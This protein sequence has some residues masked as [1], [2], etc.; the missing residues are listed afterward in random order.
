MNT[1]RQKYV[2]FRVSDSE[3]EQL[4][5]RIKNSGLNKQQFFIREVLGKSLPNEKLFQ[6]LL[7]EIKKQGVNLNQI[8]RAC[9]RGYAEAEQ[10]RIREA[11]NLNNQ[12]WKAVMLLLNTE[13]KGVDLTRLTE[14]CK[15]LEGSKEEQDQEIIKELK[16]VWQFLKL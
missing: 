6:E 5:A 14:A 10:M 16:N 8:A 7:V 2:N 4:L 15:S 9:N 1:K 3:N 13:Y 12:L 11:V